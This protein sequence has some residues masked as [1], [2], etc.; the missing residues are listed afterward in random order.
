MSDNKKSTCS[1]CCSGPPQQFD[2]TV[3]NSA[4]KNLLDPATDETTCPVMPGASVNKAAAEAAGLFRTTAIDGIG[5]VAKDV[6]HDSI[7]IP[8]STPVRRD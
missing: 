1:C 7:V 6:D 8:T 3:I 2:T 5:C 4:A